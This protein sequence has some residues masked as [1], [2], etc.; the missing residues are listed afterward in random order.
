MLPLKAQDLESIDN[1]KRACRAAAGQV[2]DNTP[3]SAF[4][5]VHLPDSSKKL[6]VVKPFLVV[7]SPS[8]AVAPLLKNLK[9]TKAPLCSGVC[10]LEQGKI[11]LL[12]QKGKLDPGMV[13]SHGPILKDLFGK[14][15]MVSAGDDKQAQ[16]AG[17]LQKM[18]EQHV[19]LSQAALHWDGTKNTVDARVKELV[20]AVKAHYAGAGTELIQEIDRTAQKIEGTLGKLDRRL[21]DSLK[22]CAGATGAARESELKK[23]LAIVE[24]FKRIVKSE[25]L[26]A[27]IDQNPFGVKTNLQAVLL[28]SLNKAEQSIG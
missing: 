17:A 6:R 10:S 14:E 7:G 27:H 5:E 26:I 25:R 16:P 23:T 19:K 9:G 28:E 2:R 15:V 18:A 21:T 13:R 4:T 1:F 3:F 8:N 12:V 20:R 24:E 22:A 11:V